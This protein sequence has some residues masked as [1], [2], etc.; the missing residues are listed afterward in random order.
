M[1]EIANLILG[2]CAKTRHENR[3]LS[4]MNGVPCDTFQCFSLYQLSFLDNEL[5]FILF[6]IFSYS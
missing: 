5:I 3:F 1:V 2:N 6:N 4:G